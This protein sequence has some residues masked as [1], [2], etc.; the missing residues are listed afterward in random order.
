MD[1]GIGLGQLKSDRPQESHDTAFETGFD[2]A[3]LLLDPDAFLIEV[4]NF[5]HKALKRGGSEVDS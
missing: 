5:S 1:I 4:Q 2:I 3:I